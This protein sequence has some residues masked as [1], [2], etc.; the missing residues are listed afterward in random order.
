MHTLTWRRS[1][2]SG[3]HGE[4]CVECAPLPA[5]MAIR[6]SKHPEAGHLTVLGG[7]WAAFL[8]AVK[9]GELDA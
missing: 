8:N 2:Y 5:S 9:R 6:D 4:N 7:E 1:S 3:A